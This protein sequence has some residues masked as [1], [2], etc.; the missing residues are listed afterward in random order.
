[1]QETSPYWNQGVEFQPVNSLQG[2][3]GHLGFQTSIPWPLPVTVGSMYFGQGALP[4][5]RE[6]ANIPQGEAPWGEY[7]AIDN[8]IPSSFGGVP[9]IDVN[10]PIYQYSR[11]KWVY[12]I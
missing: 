11:D 6:V 4:D 12:R 8:T 3:S 7:F 2:A 1:M 10:N 9:L 5:R